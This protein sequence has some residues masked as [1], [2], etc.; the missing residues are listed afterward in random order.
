MTR[1]VSALVD[2]AADFSGSIIPRETRANVRPFS[3]AAN[4]VGGAEC[5]N[6]IAFVIVI[7]QAGG[8]VHRVPSLAN[9]FKT[10]RVVDTVGACP[11]TAVLGKT[12]FVNVVAC[13]AVA[14]EASVACA[15]VTAVIVGASG[16]GVTSVDSVAFV[17]V[18]AKDAVAE[19]AIFAFALKCT[20]FVLANSVYGTVVGLN[21]ALVDIETDFVVIFVFCF[22]VARLANASV[23]A[24]RVVAGRRCQVAGRSLIQTLVII[25]T[26]VVNHAVAGDTCTNVTSNC[27]FASRLVRTRSADFTL[28][29]IRT[30]RSISRISRLTSALITSNSVTTGGVSIAIVTKIIILMIIF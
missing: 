20:W 28:V 4:S 25:R 23:A 14:G 27:V 29:N 3:V 18:G 21:L 10:A 8:G 12:A 2:V 7:A 9:A 11:I 5:R 13:F 6:N 1:L 17:D 16:V 30:G 22:F 24:N 26:R 15:R 19:E